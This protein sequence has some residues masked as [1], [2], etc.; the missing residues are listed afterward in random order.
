M[1]ITYNN[2]IFARFEYEY[3]FVVLLPEFIDINW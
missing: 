2:L 1:Q 3:G